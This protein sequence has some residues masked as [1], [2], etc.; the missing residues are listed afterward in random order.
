MPLLYKKPVELVKAPEQPPE[1]SPD[2]G[3]EPQGPWRIR[4]T[5]E[6]FYSYEY[7]SFSLRLKFFSKPCT[8]RQKIGSLPL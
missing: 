2:D 5:G 8:E 3:E 1:Q 4:F 7:V 6:I